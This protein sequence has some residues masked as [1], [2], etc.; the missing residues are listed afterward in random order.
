MKNIIYIIKHRCRM[1]LMA[2]MLFI[3]SSA[4]A[5][6]TSVHGTVIDD[7]GPLIGASVCEIDAN[8]RIIESAITDLNG[9][10]TMK[11]KNPKDKLRISY[12]GYKTQ[13]LKFD[14][15]TYNVTM[16]SDAQI[17]E[18]VVTTSRRFNGNGLPI[19][20]REVSYA[21]Q[22]LSTKDFEGLG[23]NTVDEA[24]QGRI[25]GLD[26]VGNSGNLGSGSTMRLR[27]SGSL[28]T[29]TDANPLIVVD[30]N[31]REVDLSSFDPASASD[32]KFAELLNINADDIADIRVLKD[33]AATAVYGS[34][35]G[36]GVIELVTK[37]G[38]KGKPQITYTMKLTGT[39]QPKGMNLLN[40]DDYTMLLKEAYFNPMQNDAASN[41]PEISYLPLSSFSEANQYNDN[42]DWRDAVTQW[43]LRQNHYVSLRGG[44]DKAQFSISAGFDHE[45]GTVIAQ[46]LQRFSTRVNLDYNISKRIRVST[47]FSL[48]R[49]QNYM[50]SDDLL[51]I[52]QNKMPNMSLYEEDIYGNDIPGKYYNMIQSG[53]YMGSE[54]FKDDQR[55][56]VNPV[57]SAYLAKNVSTKFD[58]N[59][60]LII[61]YELLGMDSDHHR[62]TW[63]GRVYTNVFNNYTDRFYPA[64]LVTTAWSS[65]HNN[66][67]VYSS[68]SVSFTT[69]HAL[70]FTPAFK[71]RDHSAMF[72][73]RFELTSG[74]SSWQNT[75]G[76]GLPSGG[77]ESPNAGGLVT[78]LGSSFSE[79][80]SM[81]FTLLAHY[82]YKEG[83]YSA[84]VAVRADGITKFGPD[85][86]W[87]YFP[88]VSL[89]WNVIDEPFMENARKWLSMLSIRPSWGK[90][91][92]APNQ[93][94]LYTS[95]YGSGATY[96]DMTAMVPLNL[97][98]TSLQWE[99]VNSYNLG[100]DLGF[101]NDRLKLVF[102]VF[103]STRSNMLMGNY[104]I[105]SNSG[106]S[107]L[108]YYNTG[109]LR[110]TGWEFHI[111]T[112]KLLKFGKFTMDMN[113]NFSNNRS[114]LLE[115]D[116]TVLENMNSTFNN[117][118]REILTRVQ[119]NNPLNAIYGFR[120]KG[121]YM[122]QYETIKNMDPDKQQAFIDAGNTAPVALNADGKII[123]D[124]RGDPIQMMFNYNND[125]SGKNYKFKG[126][127]A[128]Y[129]DV[130]NDGQINALDIV[131]L[132]SS[133]P[134]LMG[135]FGFS[136]AYGDWRLNAQFT[137][138]IGVDII[139]LARLDAEA[140][141]TNNNQSQAV[142]YR[143]RKEG[144]VTTIPRAMYGKDTNYN[145]LISDRFVE[146]GSYLRMSYIQL[147][148]ALNKKQLKA[149]GLN[150][151]SFHLS[152]NNP[153]IL[154]KYT[155]VD[156]DISASGYSPAQDHGQTPRARSYT[157]SLGIE[158]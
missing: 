2:S 129:E 46:K 127:D 38:S 144:D 101:M 140:M 83:R 65:G 98:L 49:T 138:R 94:Y 10:F 8:G 153:L 27:G 5:Q 66:S 19:P 151:I 74:T 150:R 37:R 110:N 33:A 26:I 156:P 14:T 116:P 89:R 152:A 13:T 91:G 50:N 57:A 54:V 11:V 41:I 55:K 120:S 97:R 157:F 25:A 61:N 79:W 149:L 32:E 9:N 128:M 105:P 145:T 86:R 121:V 123:R 143:W 51:Y 15:T 158:F 53:P 87:G 88:S 130:N 72:L 21:Y 35:G 23:L 47:N 56:Y 114:Q 117:E 52:A 109:K 77:I 3:C 17:D 96:L 45:T 75:D 42:T 141:S 155:G 108:A 134:K 63:N 71:N 59:P 18:V 67:G 82:A 69:K 73:G 102:E 147:S 12:I 103:N 122:Y 100:F 31:V 6:I 137:Y 133:L 68:K 99:M 43:G 20:E 93:N 39:Y 126:G 119:L 142:N 124:D 154:T 28:S 24:L 118:N 48:I 78:G 90:V 4:V 136:F 44:G 62:L 81:F 64:E 85:K 16:V 132:G 1:L 70:T 40:G 58:I 115:M 131:Y 125:G 84:D 139:N 111:N 7:I 148:Y 104:R 29:L 113:V 95:K 146:D 76:S 106:Y 36:N 60:E 112:N 107:T 22:G 80:R 135:G 92:N 34:Q 30:G